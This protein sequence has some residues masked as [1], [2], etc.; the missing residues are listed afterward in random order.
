MDDLFYGKKPKPKTPP[1]WAQYYWVLC[2][3]LKHC[4]LR[5]RCRWNEVM[6]KSQISSTKFQYPMT[7]TFTAVIPHRCTNFCLA[8][9]C[10]SAKILADDLFEILNL[11]NWNLFGIWCL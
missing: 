11:G 10:Y 2:L 7:K 4:Q 3:R 6:S 1:G 9:L 8:I 5:H